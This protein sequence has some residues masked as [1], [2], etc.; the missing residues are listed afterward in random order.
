MRLYEI[1]TIY[2]AAGAPVGVMFF[3]RHRA[4]RNLQPSLAMAAG[5]WLVWPAW[6]IKLFR[7]PRDEGHIIALTNEMSASARTREEK[8]KRAA[9]ALTIACYEVEDVLMKT[10]RFDSA[11][12]FV[13]IARF[14]AN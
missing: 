3:L 9:R 1:I 2:L 10:V 4:R 12:S 8:I 5:A 13:R 7:A 6:I 14:A 11:N